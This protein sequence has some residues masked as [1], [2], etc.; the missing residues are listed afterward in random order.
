MQILSVATPPTEVN[1]CRSHNQEGWTGKPHLSTL[2]NERRI[3]PAPRCQLLLH[4]VGLVPG[5]TAD[6]TTQPHEH[7]NRPQEMVVRSVVSLTRTKPNHHLHRLECVEGTL[8]TFLR[9]QSSQ[10]F[11]ANQF[12]PPGCCCAECSAHRSSCKLVSPF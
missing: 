8:P 5:F 9:Q 11:T 1:D 3:H 12:D 7:N 4:A 10:C 6:G 2:Q